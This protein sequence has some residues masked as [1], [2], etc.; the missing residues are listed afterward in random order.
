MTIPSPDQLFQQADE[1]VDN[2]APPPRGAP[3]QTYLRRAI[4]T[5]YY[6]LFH[7]TLARVADHFVGATPD[8]RRSSFYGLVYRSVAHKTVSA[9]CGDM[10]KSPVPQQYKQYMPAAGWGPDLTSYCDGFVSLQKNRHLADYDPGF[11]VLKGEAVALVATARAA[12]SS[13][14]RAPR[15]SRDAFL[16]LLVFAPR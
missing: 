9:L 13:L 16:R 10:L 14:Q 1:L 5:A 2:A 4:S 7:D 3:R 15:E 11:K 12:R 6:G 8:A